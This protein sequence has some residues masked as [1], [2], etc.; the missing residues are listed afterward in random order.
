MHTKAN[1]TSSFLDLAEWLIVKNP[2]TPLSPKNRPANFDSTIRP[3]ALSC[4]DFNSVSIADFRIFKS[5]VWSNFVLFCFDIVKSPSNLL[6]CIFN[7]AG[8][9]SSIPIWNEIASETSE[10]SPD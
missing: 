2:M 10:A 5:F 8:K 1:C 3:N 9:C 4:F 7:L 6:V